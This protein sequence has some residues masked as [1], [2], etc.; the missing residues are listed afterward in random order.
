[1]SKPG[2]RETKEKA[3][4]GKEGELKRGGGLGEGATSVYSFWVMTLP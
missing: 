3:Q 2:E 4:G 1:M